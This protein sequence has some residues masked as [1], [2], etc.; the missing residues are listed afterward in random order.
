LNSVFF[1]LSNNNLDE[2]VFSKELL[3]A[4]SEDWSKLRLVHYDELIQSVSSYLIIRSPDYDLV[5]Q[6][7]PLEVYSADNLGQLSHSRVTGDAKFYPGNVIGDKVMSIGPHVPYVIDPIGLY[8]VAREGSPHFQEHL[9]LLIDV[10]KCRNLCRAVIKFGKT[11]DSRSA[12]QFRV[13]IGCG[14]QH[15]PGGVP[16]KLVGLDFEKSL[17][18]DDCFETSSIL[19][20]VGCL[21]EFVWNVMVG[22]QREANDP[23]I[24]PDKLRHEE[25]ALFLSKYLGMDEAVG[26][27]DITLVVSILYP[28]FDGVNEHCDKMNDSMIGYKRTGTLNMCFALGHG[29]IIQLQVRDVTIIHF[30]LANAHPPVICIGHSQL[31]EGYSA[32]HVPLLFWI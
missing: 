19:Q 16:A 18:E 28:R 26:F 27:E 12:G 9:H 17:H 3:L 24:A 32:L 30:F 6:L 1:R 31:S 2:L 5:A 20:S 8:H 25:Y 23:K 10:E 21:T 7:N 29:I 14:G 15:M 22:I 11:D 13:N 4:C